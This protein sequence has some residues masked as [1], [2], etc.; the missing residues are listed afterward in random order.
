MFE[1]GAVARAR[2]GTLSQHSGGIVDELGSTFSKACE[3]DSTLEPSRH[4]AT[5]NHLIPYFFYLPPSLST[6]P[7]IQGDPGLSFNPLSYVRD[8][9]VAVETSEK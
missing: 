6:H 3:I 4:N 2:R 9:V 8:N 5:K 1:A 7:S